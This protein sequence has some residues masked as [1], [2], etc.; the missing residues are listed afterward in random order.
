MFFCE[1]LK[2][3]KISHERVKKVR[4]ILELILQNIHWL[5]IRS[6]GIAVLILMNG[7]MNLTELEI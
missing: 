7:I 6:L 3:R 1:Y 2:R 5:E 4:K